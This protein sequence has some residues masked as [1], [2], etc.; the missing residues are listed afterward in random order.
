MSIDKGSDLT[1]REI[2]DLQ[3]NAGRQRN[4]ERDGGRGIEGVGIRIMKSKLSQHLGLFFDGHLNSRSLVTKHYP[5]VEID[6]V[7]VAIGAENQMRRP[8]EPAAPRRD[9]GVDEG[10]TR[11]VVAQYLVGLPP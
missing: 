3:P 11:A 6:D 1:P 8:V 10:P 2:K 5:D 9:E 4:I 7:E